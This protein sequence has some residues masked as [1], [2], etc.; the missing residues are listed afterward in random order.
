MPTR[1]AKKKHFFWRIIRGEENENRK[2][3]RR[4]TKFTSIELFARM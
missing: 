2:A 4:W 3:E 1:N